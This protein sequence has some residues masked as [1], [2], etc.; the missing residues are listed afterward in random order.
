M[1]L[2]MLAEYSSSA[3]H[4]AEMVIAT[5]GLLWK[6]RGQKVDWKSS[7]ELELKILYSPEDWYYGLAGVTKLIVIPWRP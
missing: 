4:A 3:E 7:C 6:L 1:F 5:L 2:A